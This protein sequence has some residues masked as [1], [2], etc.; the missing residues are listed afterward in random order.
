MLQLSLQ[1]SGIALLLC[2]IGSLINGTAGTVGAATRDLALPLLS[3]LREHSEL[4]RQQLA[5]ESMKAAI[6]FAAAAAVTDLSAMAMLMAVV[7]FKARPAVQRL[8]SQE[9]P[10]QAKAS[11]F[12]S[13]MLAGVYAPISLAMLLLGSYLIAASIAAVLVAVLW[14]AQGGWSAKRR[15]TKFATI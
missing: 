14:P 5:D 8:T 4:N 11:E 10:M 15:V 13:N 1:M 9:D 2:A 3:K 12:S 6:A 7:M